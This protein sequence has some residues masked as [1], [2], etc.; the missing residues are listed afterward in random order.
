MSKNPACSV[1]RIN[2]HQ[3]DYGSRPIVTVV[4]VEVEEPDD[5]ESCKIPS[6]ELSLS[7]AGQPIHKVGDRF[8][9]L[10]EAILRLAGM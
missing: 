1:S 3:L 5:D 6:I 9:G 8:V 7:Y 2:T 4:T 10:Y